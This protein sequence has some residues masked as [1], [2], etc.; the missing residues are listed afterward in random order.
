MVSETLDLLVHGGKD[1]FWPVV[2]F[3][4][5]CASGENPPGTRMQVHAKGGGTP[6]NASMKQSHTC[7][8]KTE[9]DRCP[10]KAVEQTQ[11][12]PP[13]HNFP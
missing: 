4:I 11:V 7:Y 13:G 6:L 10:K 9:C 2:S 12:C 1:A 8:A 5:W 3:D